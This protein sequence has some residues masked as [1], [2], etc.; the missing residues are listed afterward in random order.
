MKNAIPK[1]TSG[2]LGASAE[3]IGGATQHGAA[4]GLVRNTAVHL[5]T[6]R[7]ALVTKR[8]AYEAART[9]LTD[10]K[11]ALQ[12]ATDAG[13]AFITQTR[14]LLK[15]HLGSRYSSAWDVTGL[16]RSLQ[17]SSIPMKQLPVLEAMESFL[18]DNPN[19]ENAE[20]NV[21]AVRAGE[22]ATTVT[23]AHNTVNAQK[24]QVKTAHNVRIAAAKV[25][26]KRLA[27]LV[28]ELKQAMPALDERWLAFG[29]KMPGT[30]ER[31]A[32]PTNIIA[33]LIGA[34]AVSVKWSA[35]ARAEYYRV[36]KRVV[37]LDDV[38]IAVGSPAD[39]DII[40]EGLPSNSTVEIAVSAMNNGGESALSVLATIQ[41]L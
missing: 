23:A 41:T 25:L 8:D 31:P 21:T 5:T 34:N 36:W 14:D 12:A 10:N 22:L 18:T 30:K 40:L 38:L 20:L 27:D 15:P 29:L 28:A 35:A 19:R 16:I 33:V 26:M 17:V 9:V 24:T 4:I 32:T 2:L 7:T 37:G 1:S 39:L 3:M 11:D 6:D 13:H